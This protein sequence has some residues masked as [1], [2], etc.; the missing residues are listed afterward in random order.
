MILMKCWIFLKK[1]AWRIHSGEK[2]INHWFFTENFQK[3]LEI[4]LIGVCE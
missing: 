4:L 2:E 1:R 3:L